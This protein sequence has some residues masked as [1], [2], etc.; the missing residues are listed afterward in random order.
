[1][2]NFAVAAVAA[3]VVCFVLTLAGDQVFQYYF[4]LPVDI[5]PDNSRA[6]QAYVDA[7]PESAKFI[8]ILTRAVV[9]FT[10]GFVSGFIVNQRWQI[11]SVLAGL[12]A[13]FIV[14]NAWAEWPL[15]TWM[16]VC[17]LT[18]PLPLAYL[19]AW[20]THGRK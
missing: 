9:G 10:A 4:L 19:G 2:I 12:A 11:A 17:A 3:M 15:P 6:M 1:M 16:Y 13:T 20:L 5:D 14:G 8:M 7:L 18:F